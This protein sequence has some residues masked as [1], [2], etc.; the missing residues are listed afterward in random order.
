MWE[1]SC[2]GVVRFCRCFLVFFVRKCGRSTDKLLMDHRRL[3]SS[4]QL[5]SWF[6]SP[7]PMRGVRIALP[8]E[9]KAQK[10]AQRRA[11]PSP[12]R[13]VRALKLR[14]VLR[15]IHVIGQPDRFSSPSP[16]REASRP[17]LLLIER[18]LLRSYECELRILRPI[19]RSAGRVLALNRYS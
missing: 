15:G 10:A 11:F 9:G 18:F 14:F 2:S 19:T 6:P 7:S 17:S 1:K 5:R 12:G 4:S 3:L 8:G 16:M 13:A